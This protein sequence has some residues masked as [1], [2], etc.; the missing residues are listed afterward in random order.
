LTEEEQSLI[1]EVLDTSARIKKRQQFQRRRAKIQMAK[2]VQSRRLASTS[3]LKTRAKQRARNLLIKRL[4]Q[5]R[6]RSQIPIAQRKQVD[7]KLSK[8]KRAVIRISTKLL[9]RVKQEDIARKSGKKIGKF[10]AGSSL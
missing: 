6:S 4:Y 9:R 2:R 10:N 8:M 1:N 3:R 7:Q 5:G